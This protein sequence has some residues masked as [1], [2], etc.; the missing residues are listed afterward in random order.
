[1]SA[2]QL[3]PRSRRLL[4]FVWIVLLGG[5]GGAVNAFL[6]YAKWPVEVADFDL[7]IIPCGAGHGAVIALVT[8][9][10]A[11]L[12][13]RYRFPLRFAPF[14][15]VGWLS[16]FLSYLV[17]NISLSMTEPMA[18]TWRELFESADSLLLWPFMY[19]GLVG[20]LYY[21][22]LG[23]C[24]GLRASARVVHIVLAGGSGVLGSL[25]WWIMWEHWYL[26][27]LHGTIWGLLVGYGVWRSQRPPAGQPEV[28][29]RAAR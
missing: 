26:S 7:H 28:E 16:G 11:M 27:P 13:E 6:C 25:Y 23:V 17:L 24:R 22:A 18:F 20:L 29:A 12:L 19:F 9:G 15:A 4:P 2:G 8:V 21:V 3:A 10:A 1:M 14:A 5:A